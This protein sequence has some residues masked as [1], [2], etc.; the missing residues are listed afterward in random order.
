[1]KRSI[2][3]IAS[4]LLIAFGSSAANAQSTAEKARPNIVFILMDDLRSDELG[5]TGHPFVQ[6]PN[7]D[8]L[9]KEGCQF[10]NAFATTPL[11]SPSRAS[12]LTGHYA[13]KHGILDN[14]D[15]SPRTHELVTW[16]RLLHD[17]GYETAF[18]GK[19]HM[20]VDDSPRPGF[21]HWVSVRGQGR[22]LDPEL[23]VDGQ[24]VTAKGYVTDL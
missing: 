16:P 24:R 12:F 15:R 6:T 8:R 23:N 20:G 22:Y 18:I 3:S 11:C 13:H 19:W 4:C 7:I 17:A 10:K 5:C 14:T 21:D 1:M 2:F 9:A